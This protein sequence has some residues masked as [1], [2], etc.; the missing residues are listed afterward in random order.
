MTT[1]TEQ[2]EA[3]LD[4]LRF[5]SGLEREAARQ[6]LRAGHPVDYESQKIDYLK[7]AKKAKYNPDFI[8]WKRDGTPMFIETKGRFLTA[9]R[10]KHL[11]IKEQHPDLDIRFVFQRAKQTIGKTSTTTYAKWCEKKGFRFADGG[12]IPKE[13]FDE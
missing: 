12:K 10:S 9:D 1:T 7:P 11:L 6:I 4:R 2:I 13:W 8:I 5:R 3:E